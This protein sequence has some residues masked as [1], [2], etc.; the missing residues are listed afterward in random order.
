VT[1]AP[2]VRN[3][4][5]REKSPK[6]RV[7]DRGAVTPAPDVRN[8][9]LRE[10]SPKIRV[11]DRGAVTPAPDVRN[12]REGSPLTLAIERREVTP[13]P[14]SASPTAFPSFIQEPIKSGREA[15]VGE[16]RQ[17]WHTG[18]RAGTIVHRPLQRRRTVEG[19]S[20][21][22]LADGRRTPPSV[23]VGSPSRG[24]GA[25][26]ETRIQRAPS[27]SKTPSTFSLP[28]SLADRIRDSPASEEVTTPRRVIPGTP[29]AAQ[30]RVQLV[31]RPPKM[32]SREAVSPHARSSPSGSTPSASYNPPKLR[33]SGETPTHA[34]RHTGRGVPN[35]VASLQFSSTPWQGYEDIAKEDLV[36][37]FVEFL[38]L[39]LAKLPRIC[40]REY[41]SQA[42]L[43]KD[44]LL[45]LAEMIGE[46]DAD[47]CAMLA[48]RRVIGE[49][50]LEVMCCRRPLASRPSFRVA[51]VVPVAPRKP[52]TRPIIASVDS[53]S[54][55]CTSLYSVGSSTPSARLSAT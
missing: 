3:T 8:T 20:M 47:D 16:A 13:A 34:A 51:V 7:F 17:V 41:D 55:M 52:M 28:F 40:P 19:D 25:L 39:K 15:P 46:S 1:P 26:S 27:C 22:P 23:E 32:A 9:N 48:A 53:V 54:T 49:W 6:I 18:A 50:P 36:E 14:G 31:N 35:T 24:R 10:K 21:T 33:V 37:F 12:L 45:W 38:R 2:D 4:N 5:L 43:D 44:T 29:R 11:F 42:S 30:T